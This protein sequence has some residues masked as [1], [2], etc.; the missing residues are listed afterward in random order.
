MLAL[1]LVEEAEN[2]NQYCFSYNVITV[3][4]WLSTKRSKN[5]YDFF[6]GNKS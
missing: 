1:Y 2:E 5:F 3:T 6:F 4:L